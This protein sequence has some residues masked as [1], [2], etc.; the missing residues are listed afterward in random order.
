[1]REEERRQISTEARDALIPQGEP[2]EV[3]NP[4]H[5]PKMPPPNQPQVE[6]AKMEAPKTTPMDV[7]TT[8]SSAE[9]S[10]T[11][12]DLNLMKAKPEP[13]GEVTKEESS[14]PAFILAPAFMDI[15]C[16]ECGAL[17]QGASPTNLKNRQL[18]HPFGD[19]PLGGVPCRFKGR[20]FKTPV[21]RVDLL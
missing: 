9:S 8:A 6:T 7:P 5:P 10:T 14:L 17:L 20:M 1:M 13:A 21:I 2:V 18:Q 15:V 4:R 19:P 16:P 3:E 11:T 12:M